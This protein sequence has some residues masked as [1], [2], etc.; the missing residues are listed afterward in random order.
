VG[1]WI[2]GSGETW[3]PDAGLYEGLAGFRYALRRFLASS[4][5]MTRAAGVTPQQY[6]ALLVIKT[7]PDGAV[8]IKDLADQMLLQ[9]NGAVQLID[10][11]AHAGLVE[12]RQSST[13]GRSVLVVMTAKGAG[14]LEHLASNHVKELLRHEPLLAESLRR[15]RQVVR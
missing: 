10:R 9:H 1:K 5:A 14:L 13:D 6:Q 12:R 2:V 11:L 3:A 7:A 4:E 15:L 8:M